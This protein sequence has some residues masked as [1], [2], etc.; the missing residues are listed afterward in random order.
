MNKKY[1]LVSNLSNFTKKTK[2]I[3]ITKCA[4]YK[5]S[6]ICIGMPA[7]IPKINKNV[8]LTVKI[9]ENLYLFRL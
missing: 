5:P 4:K 2:R 7:S 1:I 3:R 9:F 6:I 8:C